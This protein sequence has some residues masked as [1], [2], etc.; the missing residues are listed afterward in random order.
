MFFLKM[1]IE[2]WVAWIEF[3]T[4]FTTLFRLISSINLTRAINGL[5]IIN[6]WFLLNNASAVI[7]C[8]V[9]SWLGWWF[10]RLID[11]IFCLV[12]LFNF[13]LLVIWWIWFL[14]DPFGSTYGIGRSN[15]SMFWSNM[16]IEWWSARV[17]LPTSTVR[18]RFFDEGWV[19][20]FG[21]LLN[22]GLDSIDINLW[23][24]GLWL[25]GYM[26]E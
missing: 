19:C 8:C 11:I 5:V 23:A 1:E 20:R 13:N 3:T 9:W 14:D 2:W 18:L 15:P 25:V 7:H 17:I 24:V 16:Q 12:I 4:N 22:F 6:R 10:S 21:E 26:W